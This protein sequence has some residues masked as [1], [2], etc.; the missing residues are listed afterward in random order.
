MLR[1]NL[2]T[3]VSWYIVVGCLAASCTSA[4]ATLDGDESATTTRS[5]FCATLES[6]RAGAAF[7]F[8]GLQAVLGVQGG[9]TTKPQ[10]NVSEILRQGYTPILGASRFTD[11]KIGNADIL[12]NHGAGI[13]AFMYF[14]KSQQ[15]A[16]P[17]R[18]RVIL[19]NQVD[20]LLGVTDASIEVLHYDCESAVWEPAFITRERAAEPLTWLGP[21]SLY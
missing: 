5:T 12:M 10:Q 13:A 20:T 4:K 9:R 1:E 18:P 8:E 14:T 6:K 19:W 2:T 11:A 16:S 7:T 21:Q 3:V 17:A 15:E